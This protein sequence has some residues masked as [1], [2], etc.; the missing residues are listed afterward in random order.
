MIYK[1]ELNKNMIKKVTIIIPCYNIAEYL[2]DCLGSI[3][4]QT[5]PSI[6][7]ILI[8][9]G[10]TDKTPEIC[11]EFV[12]KNNNAKVF[13]INNSGV[14]NAR[15]LGIK[16]S[17]GDYI[18]FVDADDMI[19]PDYIKSLYQA[20]QV[21]KSDIVYCKETHFSSLNF[22][23]LKSEEC[24]NKFYDIS[25]VSDFDYC[26]LMTHSTVW[27]CLFSRKI[28]SDLSFRTDIFIAEDSL[29]FNSA[30]IK[31]NK[32]GFLDATLYYYRI[33]NDSATGKTP[34]S[35][36]KMTEIVSWKEIVRQNDS[37]YP[38]SP[39][40]FSSHY[41]LGNNAIKG[42]KLMQVNGGLQKDRVDRLISIIRNEKKY[43]KYTSISCKKKLYY[44]LFSKFPYICGWAYKKL[45]K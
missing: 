14:S 8:N 34:Y 44:Y 28:V 42:I 38:D 30:I 19:S 16:E 4:N 7:I 36:K 13:H 25:S 20:I 1:K 31:A 45:V 26:G 27:G 10:S 32:I 22:Q 39:L 6:E 29:F 24:N 17:T 3:Q 21:S 12:R 40:A 15:N 33:R 9:D 23:A 18:T 43:I 37:M 2:S 5:Y 35:D 41:C 11:D